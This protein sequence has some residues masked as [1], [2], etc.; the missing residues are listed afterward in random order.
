M[1]RI[2]ARTK[3]KNLVIRA[4]GNAE[5]LPPSFSGKSR[6]RHHTLPLDRDFESLCLRFDKQSVR[7]KAEKARRAGVIVEERS[8]KEGMAL[9]HSLLAATRRRLSLPPMPHRFFDAVQGN[10]GP[11]HLKVFL[12]YQ[13]A[14]PVACHIVL[15]FKDQWI[16][17][18]SGNAAGAI[19][20]VNQL[21][22]LETIRQACAAGARKFSFGRTS[23]HS[24][25]LL[26]YKRRWG[27]IEEKLTD[28]TLGADH[29]KE[30]QVPGGVSRSDDSLAY[31]L[32]KQ[33]IA[34]A[35]MPVCRMIGDFCYRHLG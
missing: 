3:S 12:A 14:K 30:T 25:G 24:E 13:N 26:S 7:Q 17:E 6:F 11:G 15:I 1:E 32:C 18:Y 20:G 10:L 21:L 5:P 28:Y 16:S 23:I 34:N 8:D 31:A 2:S 27:T 22:Y 35:P 29:G 19:S 4:V 9:S 33:V